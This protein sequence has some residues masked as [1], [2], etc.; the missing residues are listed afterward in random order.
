MPN[1]YSKKQ[2][3]AKILKLQSEA[4]LQLKNNPDV[5]K[6][7]DETDIFDEWE[8][9]LPEKEFPIFVIT[10]LNNIKSKTVISSIIESISNNNGK[11][12]FNKS[13]PEISEKGSDD[14]PFC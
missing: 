14:H 3:Y 5:D 4:A 13:E 7:I 1:K 2:L 9:I 6:F 12:I 11:K 8:N 10:I